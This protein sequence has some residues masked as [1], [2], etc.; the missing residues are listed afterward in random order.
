MKI[1]PRDP[2]LVATY[3]RRLGTRSYVLAGGRVIDPANKRDA[4]GD[5]AVKDGVIVSEIPQG[6]T[7]EVIDVSGL[8]VCP[9][10]IDLH[11]HLREPGQSSKETIATGTRAAAAG[12]FT[13]IVAMPNTKPVADS[14]STIAWM[15][16]R[17][18]ETGIINVYTTGCISQGMNGEALAPIGSLKQAGVVA[19]TDDGKC[20]QN[21][22]LMRRALEYAQMFDL[23]LMDHC[24]DYALSE[25]GVM[26]EGYWSTVLGLQGWPAIAE[27]VIVGRNA[28]LAELT[29]GTIH[30]QHLS[31]AGSVRIVRE[32]RQRGVKISGEVMP[33]HIA[34]TDETI[35]GYDT[36]FKMNPPLRT[37]RDVQALLEGLADGSID[38][39]GSDHAPHSTYEKEVEFAEAPFG[40][41]GLETELSLFIK[42]LIEPGVLNWTRMIEKL[43]INPARL[44]RLN[45][46]TLTTGAEA[47][48]TLIDPARE[49][50]VD[51]NQFQ[52][53]SRNTPFHGWEL[54]GRAV[55][56]I[57][58]GEFV[59]SC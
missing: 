30:C 12:G 21:N 13:T 6:E 37:K 1:A 19:I 51:K 24:Q 8:I 44:L 58:G 7:M 25:G 16:Q 5:V 53:K 20:I 57:V 59:F 49:W 43:T 55:A 56:T 17:I 45:K 36:N 29:G 39:L 31:T 27:E 52:S 33:H 38:I 10:L 41:L 47:D 46:G 28:L 50:V 15:R 26:N 42:T 40:I 32:A 48:I 3:D 18:A 9:G 23:P 35:E 14:A 34:L 2:S 4:I 54:K 22:E 11:V